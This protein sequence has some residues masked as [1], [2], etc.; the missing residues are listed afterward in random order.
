[1]KSYQIWE[2]YYGSLDTYLEGTPI[3]PVYGREK[4]FQQM[5]LYEAEWEVWRLIGKGK[6]LPNVKDLQ[7]YIDNI[8][9]DTWVQERFPHLYIGKVQVSGMGRKSQCAVNM[10]HEIRFADFLRYELP[11]IHELVHSIVPL[12]DHSDHGRLFARIYLE[13][14]AKFMGK[15]WAMALKWKFKDLGVEYKPRK[16]PPP[17][18][19]S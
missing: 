15:R 10:L 19:V 17:S 8:I 16:L 2:K 3:D 6:H 14:V 11:A 7:N 13:M 1:M 9:G 4:D 5:K 18:P 12:R